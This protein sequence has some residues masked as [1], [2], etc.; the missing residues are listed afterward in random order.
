MDTKITSIDGVQKK[1]SGKTVESIVETL[2]KEGYNVKTGFSSSP[3]KIS[4]GVPIKFGKYTPDIFAFRGLNEILLVEFEICTNILSSDIENKWRL[5]SSK[6]R[7]N[8]HLI[9]P[10]GCK[11]KF[12]NRS[13]VKN[14]PVTIHCIN[15]CVDSF[16]NAM[17][18][19][20]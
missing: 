19:S 20:K 9:V 16:R 8:L 10:Y 7:Q 5:L 13:R 1:V 15:N 11:Q 12:E 2:Q 17:E 4:G 3:N 14:I 6:S 18:N